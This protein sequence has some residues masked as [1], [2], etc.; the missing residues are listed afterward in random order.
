MEIKKFLNN[1]KVNFIGLLETKV[2]SNNSDQIR[3]KLGRCWKWED[4]YDLS[5]RGRIWVGWNT[6]MMSFDIYEKHEQWIHGIVIDKQT[7]ERLEITTIYGLHTVETR[8]ALW[9]SLIRLN[10]SI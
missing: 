4:N 7:G 10:N 3:K 1:N 9:A 8:K 6:D 5:P 2:R